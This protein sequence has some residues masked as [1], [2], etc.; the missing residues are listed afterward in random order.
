ME[1]SKGDAVFCKVRGNYYIHLVKA[2]KNSRY[3]IANRKGRENGWISV[4]GIFG[5]VVQIGE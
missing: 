2:V 5:K 4:E 3:L 1:I